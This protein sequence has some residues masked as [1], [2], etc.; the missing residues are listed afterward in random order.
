[1]NARH[2]NLLRTLLSQPTAPFHEAAIV[3]Q[4]RRWA[5]GRGVSFA[6]DSS[7]NVLLRY[8]KGRAAPVRWV[9]S[10]HMDHPGFVARRQRGEQLWADFLGSVRREYFAGSR[11]RFFAPRGEVVARIVGVRK[12]ANS[13]WLAC[14]LKLGQAAEVPA[15]SIG[16]WDLPAVRIRGKRLAGRA[17]DDVVGTAAVLCAMDEIASRRLSADVTGLLTRA[18]EAAFIGAMAACETGS[19]PQDAMIVA[20][21]TSAAQPAARLGDGVVVRVGDRVRTYDP[22]LTG[23]VSAVAESLRKRDRRFRYARQ[24]MPG[25]TC[26][27]TAYAMWGYVATGLC[28]PLGNYHN[29][30]KAGRIAAEQIHLDDFA[31]LVKLLVALAVDRRRPGDADAMLRGQL[32]RLLR[33][34]RKFL[35]PRPKRGHAADRRGGS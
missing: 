33:T 4:A 22:S 21:E 1:V 17:C 16:M 12:P 23:H 24:L 29:Q 27:S 8:R 26:E 7:G 14:R 31:S 11:V 5:E 15:G 13:P 34:R 25:G 30:G 2:L 10:A 3:L 35:W 28:L 18:E 19:I 20:M 9:F 32:Q 6:R